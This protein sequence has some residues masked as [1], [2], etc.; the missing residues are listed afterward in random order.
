VIAGGEIA[1]VAGMFLSVPII[2]AIRII[3]RRLRT[4]D[5]ID[6]RGAL[7]CSSTNEWSAQSPAST[8]KD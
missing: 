7:D 3:W 1:G 2:A 6:K 5:D 4:S 8:L